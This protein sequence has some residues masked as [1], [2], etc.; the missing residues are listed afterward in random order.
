MVN[1]PANDLHSF[2]VGDGYFKAAIICRRGHVIE[3]GLDP[4]EISQMD[5][6]RCSTCG[7]NTLKACTKCNQRLKGRYYSPIVV[8]FQDFQ[9]KPFCDSCGSAM[10]WASRQERIWELQNILDENQL[11]EVEKLKI[12]ELLDALNNYDI[13]DATE[14][15]IWVKIK[16]KLGKVF[17]NERVQNLIFDLAGAY[18]KKNMGI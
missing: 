7:A 8:S 13:D 5:D 11:D 2:R 14:S 17:Y 6:S 9:P 15:D 4:N 18:A 10:P 16:I 3:E 1:W 12:S